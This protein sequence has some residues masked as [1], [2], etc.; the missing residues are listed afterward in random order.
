MNSESRDIIDHLSVHSH[1]SD[2][3]LEIENEQTTILQN[4]QPL[5]RVVSENVLNLQSAIP[6]TFA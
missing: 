1:N 5:V 4:E 6:R 3:P 2:P